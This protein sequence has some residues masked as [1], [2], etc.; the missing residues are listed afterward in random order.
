MSSSAPRIAPA[1]A[2]LSRP[3]VASM[4]ALA[5]LTRICWRQWCCLTP[6][7]SGAST[8]SRYTA[9]GNRSSPDAALTGLS[10]DPREHDPAHD[11]L[12]EQDEHQEHR[13]GGDAGAGHH[14]L[15]FPLELA[16]ERREPDGE[17]VE[18]AL[19]RRGEGGSA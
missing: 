15:P 5:R 6:S 1:S 3:R 12:L 9:A 7:N 11:V 19:R 10:L 13:D 8:V 2:R 14:H 16:G 17:R 18:L 4:I